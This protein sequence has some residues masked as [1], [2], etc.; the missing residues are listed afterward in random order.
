MVTFREMLTRGAAGSVL[1]V[2]LFAGSAMR[3]LRTWSS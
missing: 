1:A 3:R 2:A